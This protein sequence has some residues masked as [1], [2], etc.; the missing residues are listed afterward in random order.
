M[1]S[2]RTFL[3]LLGL[4]V[5]VACSPALNWRETRPQGA[6]IVAMF[7]C[8]PDRHARTVI[9]AAAKVQMQLLACKAGGATY[10][11]SFIDVA[12]PSGVTPA[13]GELR[14]LVLANL[15]A[16]SA[17]TL[18]LPLAGITPNPQTARLALRGRLPD[19]A[20]VQAQAAFFARGLRIY[21][22]SVIGST[23]APEAV[24]IFFSGLRFPS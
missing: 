8:R 17:Q 19:A 18:P 4:A 12:E 15:G 7:P 6:D 23:L 14:A 11:L 2:A 20:A 9:V 1:T 3:P 10:A 16:G 22:A 21:Q 13:L 5:S 24:D